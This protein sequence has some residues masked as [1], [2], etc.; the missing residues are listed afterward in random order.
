[1]ASS[2]KSCSRRH[3]CVVYTVPLK[4]WWVFTSSQPRL[5]IGQFLHPT[6]FSCAQATCASRGGQEELRLFYISPPRSRMVSGLS[7]DFFP[8]QNTEKRHCGKA[9]GEISSE[10]LKQRRGGAARQCCNQQ[11]PLQHLKWGCCIWVG[12]HP[13]RAPSEGEALTLVCCA[14]QGQTVCGAWSASCSWVPSLV[15][16]S[17]SLGLSPFSLVL[18]VIHG[19]LTPDFSPSL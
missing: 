19:I 10:M 4:E 1:M 15:C 18:E 16:R 2:C 17:I 8:R 3:S 11:L 12:G 6:S 5:R 13:S 7:C 14:S 9:S